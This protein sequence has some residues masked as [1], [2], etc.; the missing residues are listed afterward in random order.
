MHINNKKEINDFWLA[1]IKEGKY[2]WEFI[3]NQE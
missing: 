3:E 2:K 1:F